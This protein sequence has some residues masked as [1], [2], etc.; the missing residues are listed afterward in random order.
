MS[1]TGVV[2]KI[3]PLISRSYHVNLFQNFIEEMEDE[4]HEVMAFSLK[5]DLTKS[6][7]GTFKIKNQYYGKHSQKFFYKTIAPFSTRIT[8]LRKLN[9][10]D[11]DLI[12]SVNDLPLAPFTTLFE[13]PSVV[14]L[15]EVPGRR[16]EHLI[17]NYSSKIVTPD[18]YHSDVPENK[19]LT[20]SSYHTLAY[21][22]PNRF[23]P[24]EKVLEK[25]DV[26]SKEYVVVS[27]RGKT[28]L[29]MDLK[30]ELLKRR[31]MIDLV[32]SLD[33]H[34]QVFVDDRGYVPEPLEEYIP[35][36]PPH[37]YL[38]L[39]VHAKLVV[40]NEPI[41][42]SEAGVLGVPWIYV[43]NSTPYPLEDQEI[44]YEIGSQVYDVEEAEEL[45]KKILTGEV[46]PDFEI[47]RKQILKD[48]SDLTNWM[49]T[50]VRA[51]DKF[52]YI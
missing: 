19:Q 23:T 41:I 1:T 22:H 21:L 34:V 51:M 47:S 31:E 48:K 9:K 32:R 44:R 30:G 16:K 24:D 38:D 25:L 37:Q 46:E 42:S 50:L 17:F 18:C 29:D 43:S 15:D 14:F 27:F 13:A 2:L 20:H 26:S 4:G 6:L 11:P 33:D 52:D 5:D 7:L 36:I 8:L 45:A 28:Y 40:G 49:L 3:S 10:F 12:L 35:S 39:L